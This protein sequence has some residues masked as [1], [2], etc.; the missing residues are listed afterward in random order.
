MMR[1]DIAT[2][3]FWWAKFDLADQHLVIW[4]ILFD[5]FVMPIAQLQFHNIRNNMTPYYSKVG[6]SPDLQEDSWPQVAKSSQPAEKN[7]A[8]QGE[9]GVGGLGDCRQQCSL[10]CN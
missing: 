3:T 6:I 7:S 1:L 2:K 4:I 10:H 9:R 8:S 5:I